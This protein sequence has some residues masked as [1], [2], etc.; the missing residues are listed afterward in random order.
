LSG[1]A[2]K[3]AEDAKGMGL[4]AMKLPAL[5]D[6]T[7][8]AT[9]AA[10]AALA[11]EKALVRAAAH[12]DRLAFRALYERTSAAAYRMAA[13][14]VH[15]PDAAE[16]VVQEAFCQAWAGIR[17]F[18]GDSQFG[19]WVLSIARHVALDVLRRARSRRTHPSTDTLDERPSR[20]E[21]VDSRMRGDE[22]K[23]ALEA[24]LAELPEESRTA[25]Q[26]A[27][28]ERLSY[29]DVAAVLGTTT[30]GIKCRVFRVR[31]H[32]RARLS[33]FEDES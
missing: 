20:E 33:R 7:R 15:R 27:A 22:L 11:E 24:A 18:K 16:E 19:T 28:L 26:L 10:Q 1:R 6:D 32:L 12:G 3:Q 8:P 9:A 5:P 25:F 31:E 2:T 29:S 4:P 21:R 14:I 30:D 17:T 23:A 13:R